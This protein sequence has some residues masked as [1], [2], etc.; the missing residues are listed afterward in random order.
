MFRSYLPGTPCR[1]ACRWGPTPWG[2]SPSWPRRQRSGAGSKRCTWDKVQREKKIVLWAREKV[3]LLS[4]KVFNNLDT[5]NQSPFAPNRSL[6]CEKKFV[7][8]YNVK[9]FYGFCWWKKPHTFF[10]QV[11][12][13]K[14]VWKQNLKT[15]HAHLSQLGMDSTGQMMPDMMR[16]G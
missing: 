14:I 3:V 7:K 12:F 1:P 9:V 15:R 13:K 11:F 6:Q 16:F 8:Q 4:K 2:G 10:V 5:A